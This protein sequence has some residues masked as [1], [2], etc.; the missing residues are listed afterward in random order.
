MSSDGAAD[1][2]PGQL[3]YPS[4]EPVQEAGSAIFP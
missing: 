4:Q 3:M 2:F 1:A